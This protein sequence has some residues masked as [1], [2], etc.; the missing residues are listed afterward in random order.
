MIKK[1]PYIIAVIFSVFFARTIDLSH[2]SIVKAANLAYVNGS[3]FVSIFALFFINAF[4]FTRK[5][6]R[7]IS[8]KFSYEK[9]LKLTWQ[10]FEEMTSEYFLLQGFKSRVV[11]GGGSDGGIDVVIEKNGRSYIVQCKHWKTKKVGVQIVREMY[12][13]VHAH[14]AYGAKVVSTIGYSKQAYEFAKGKPIELITGK[15]IIEETSKSR[16]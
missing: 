9:L 16:A 1:A 14:N 3:L 7:F 15:Q 4:V 8:E 5:S 11:G 12:G 6:T 2:E 10:Q 13:L